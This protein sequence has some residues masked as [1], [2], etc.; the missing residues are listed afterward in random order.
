V[1]P[2]ELL[3]PAM[4][5]Q[6]R[7]ITS[8]RRLEM[9]A[10]RKP[11]KKLPPRRTKP[12]RI[13]DPEAEQRYT[14]TL[15]KVLVMSE[16]HGVIRWVLK[17]A[18]AAFRELQAKREG[19]YGLPPAHLFARRAVVAQYITSLLHEFDAITLSAIIGD[20]LLEL[21][22]RGTTSGRQ[23]ATKAGIAKEREE[24][25]P[26]AILLVMRHAAHL[27][28]EAARELPATFATEL[29]VYTAKFVETLN[30]IA[31]EQPEAVRSV[32]S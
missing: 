31:D 24:F 26:W 11:K 14:K 25:A 32:A 8:D 30:E 16:R 19:P 21:G 20:L 23:L 9:N 12:K 13:S 27:Y 5:R 22:I 17:G 29:A 6:F 1:I 28:C 7:Q 18:G 2:N 4:D 10:K 3:A 15:L